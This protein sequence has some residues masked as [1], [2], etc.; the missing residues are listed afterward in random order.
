MWVCLA[1]FRSVPSVLISGKF[2]RFPISSSDPVPSVFIRGQ[3]LGF[4]CQFLA[5]PAI[6]AI[7]FGPLPSRFIPLHPRSSQFGVGLSD[8][9]PDHPRLAW[10]SR[11]WV[12]I[13]VGFALPLCVSSCPLWLTGLG[14][15]LIARCQLLA[16]DFQRSFRCHAEAMRPQLLTLY[17]FCSLLSSKKGSIFVRSS[18][19]TGRVKQGIYARSL[20]SFVPHGVEQAFMPNPCKTLPLT[21]WS[22]HS[23]LR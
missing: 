2:S 11:T 8:F 22:R 18:V 14:F 16:A 4:N 19:Y 9:I 13:G 7:F 12:L 1:F 10:V 20:Q 21:G 5:I 17:V 15:R 23:C 3:V 6:L